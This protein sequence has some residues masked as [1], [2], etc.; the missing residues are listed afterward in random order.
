MFVSTSENCARCLSRVGG[1]DFKLRGHA[2][3]IAL[4]LAAGV[5]LVT[6]SGM[7]SKSKMSGCLGAALWGE[8]EDVC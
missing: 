4:R 6:M 1:V 5:R 8:T 7:T 3:T 2:R